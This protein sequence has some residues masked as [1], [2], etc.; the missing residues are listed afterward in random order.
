MIIKLKLLGLIL[1]LQLMT[2]T[3][4]FAMQPTQGFKTEGQPVYMEI[5]TTEDSTTAEKT[6]QIWRNEK[7]KIPKLDISK[8]TVIV[9]WNEVL[10]TRIISKGDKIKLRYFAK[11]QSSSNKSIKGDVFLVSDSTIVITSKRKG[12]NV[13]V[14]LSDVKKV[15]VP[16]PYGVLR[17]VGAVI[18]GGSRLIAGLGLFATISSVATEEYEVAAVAGLVT[19]SM[20]IPHQLGRHVKYEYYQI[21][22]DWS[23]KV[24]PGQ[25]ATP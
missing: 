14:H 8:D 16:S 9:K 18:V 3:S 13:T 17:G 2:T 6:L 11:S 12:T 25:P 4:C 23:L 19:L 24:A 10:P 20:A 7:Y 15:I 22:S 5:D 1:V 21:G